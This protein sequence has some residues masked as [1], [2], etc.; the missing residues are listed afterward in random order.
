MTV[1][2]YRDGIMAADGATWQGDVIAS[3]N[4]KKIKRTADGALYACAGCLSDIQAF[5]N[6][7]AEGRTGD[8]PKTT[9]AFGVIFVEPDG[10]VLKYIRDAPSYESPNP[11]AIEGGAE[12]FMAALLCAGFTAEQTV[13]MAIKHTSWAAGE[14]Q[15]EQL[16]KPQVQILLRIP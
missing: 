2:V 16:W 12:E 13:H 7:V 1:I 14:V 6:W 9:D 5:G 10:R 3:F 15:I 4:A 8:R 11:W